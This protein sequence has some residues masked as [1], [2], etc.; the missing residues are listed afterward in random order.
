M[1]CDRTEAI[2][3]IA[4]AVD[5]EKVFGSGQRRNRHVLVPSV[6]LALYGHAMSSNLR[7]MVQSGHTITQ[8]NDTNSTRNEQFSMMDL[9]LA[10]CRSSVLAFLPARRNCSRTRLPRDVDQCKATSTVDFWSNSQTIV[11]QQRGLFDVVDTDLMDL[12]PVYLSRC[13]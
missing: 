6:E 4:E 10:V 11:V 12:P 9:Y 8:T 3:S 13:Q 2:E 5:P 1:F 7:V